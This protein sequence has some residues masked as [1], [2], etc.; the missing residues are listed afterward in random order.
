MCYRKIKIIKSAN[1][2]HL[3]QTLILSLP[4]YINIPRSIGDA[5]RY[6]KPLG[7]IGCMQP[8]KLHRFQMKSLN[9]SEGKTHLGPDFQKIDI[10]YNRNINGVLAI[11]EGLGELASS[12]ETLINL[13]V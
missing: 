4:A 3:H 5:L 12:T 1:Q 8:C 13:V 10:V 7:L 2:T 6:Q 9:E 11:V